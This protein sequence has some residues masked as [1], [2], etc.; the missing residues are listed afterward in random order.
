MFERVTCGT[1]KYTSCISFND[2][3]IKL[4][5]P[6]SDIVTYSCTRPLEYKPTAI[7]ARLVPMSSVFVVYRQVS[8]TL[9]TT[10]LH[11][12]TPMTAT[13][14]PCDTGRDQQSSSRAQKGH[15]NWIGVGRRQERTRRGASAEDGGSG[16]EGEWWQA[17]ARAN[18]VL[19]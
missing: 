12:R 3:L 11:R 17:A 4:D 18:G 9:H 6:R 5:L 2:R 16:R 1:S 14:L 7:V 8:H 13:C 19:G 15:P 10:V